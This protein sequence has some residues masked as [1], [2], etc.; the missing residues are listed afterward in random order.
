MKLNFDSKNTYV[1]LRRN[2]KRILL[3][4]K[5]LNTEKLNLIN[6][7]YNNLDF[8]NSFNKYLYKNTGM[9]DKYWGEYSNKRQVK[10][11]SSSLSYNNPWYLFF[12]E[13]EG[14][15]HTNYNSMDKIIDLEKILSW[16]DSR[17]YKEAWLR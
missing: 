8:I 15:L 13:V 2:L 4:K 14:I 17:P 16:L 1:N 11:V 3:N 5:I 10:A 12:L 7:L 9:N 6:E